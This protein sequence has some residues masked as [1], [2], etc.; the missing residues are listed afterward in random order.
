METSLLRCLVLLLSL[1]MV[2]ASGF[3]QTLA[4][5]GWQGSGWTVERWWE[6]AILYRLNPLT[7]QHPKGLGAVVQRLD[8]LQ[9]LG[10]DALVL[11]PFPL[12][13]AGARGP[14]AS[15]ATAPFDAAYGTE[16]DLALL[17]KEA[18]RRHMRVLVDLPFNSTLSDDETA[19]A[20][21]FWLSRGVA[22]LSLTDASLSPTEIAPRN[23]ALTAAQTASRLAMLGRLCA[24]YPG[25]RILFWDLPESASTSSLSAASP[26]HILRRTAHRQTATAPRVA[27]AGAS[28]AKAPQLVL[29]GRLLQQN[30]WQAAEL[31]ALLQASPHP[32]FPLATP[33][34]AS[35]QEG[36]PRSVDRFSDDTHPV[37][38]ARQTAALLLL[39]Q[40]VPELYAGQEIG[41]QTASSPPAAASGEPSPEASSAQAAL[42]EEDE[43]SL[44]NWYRRL[45]NVRHAEL[46]VRAGSLDV[47]ALD[48]LAHPDLVAWIRSPRPGAIGA[49]PVLILC[50]LSARAVTVS[51]TAELRARGI[52][53][54]TGLLRTL[55]SSAPA[56]DLSRPV[57]LSGIALAAYG[58]YVGE[59]RLQPGLESV[60]V[61]AR[62]RPGHSSRLSTSGR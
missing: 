3:A 17:V 30:R 26:G 61:P 16:D 25:Q 2:S 4:R 59:L 12:E 45:S 42:E 29:D 53:V 5:P 23:R 57:P 38:I 43:H 24:S 36:R 51:L 13:A 41:R 35:D 22:G 49:A 15:A 44:L 48:H 37:E 11:S 6:S 47:L 8:Y 32:V 52:A 27:A 7:F 14:S 19:D 50:N 31:R 55:A 39:G 18:S 54:G 60:P 20:A 1:A 56:A 10:V 46:A 62:H 33:V 28:L 40:P 9:S 58:V 34:L 21:R